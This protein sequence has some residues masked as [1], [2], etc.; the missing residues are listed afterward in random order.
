[1]SQKTL[2]RILILGEIISPLIGAIID[3]FF[4]QLLPKALQDYFTSSDSSEFQWGAFWI[5][6][7]L[8]IAFA[9]LASLYGLWR[10]RS[11][12]RWLYT[13]LFLVYFYPPF[14]EPTVSSAIANICSELSSGCSGGILVLI[15]VS[16]ISRE[17]SNQPRKSVK[18][19]FNTGIAPILI[20]LIC[21]FV[22]SLLSVAMTGDP[23]V[24]QPWKTFE[25]I[26]FSFIMY[27]WYYLDKAQH[28]YRAG[29]WLNMAVVGC[30]IIA[31]PVYL[32]R[33]RPLRQ[34]VMAFLMFL[35]VIVG[36][37]VSFMVGGGIGKVIID[38]D[39]CETVFNH[40]VNQS[41]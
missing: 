8:G 40:S 28:D 26:L 37:G 14:F 5:L 2:L 27:W 31:V 12:A 21:V 24:G 30:G 7:I 38:L 4:P 20:L 17:F 11:W 1:M 15:W 39:G 16:E 35:L 10:L 9:Y 22:S 33:S 36:V 32:F 18:E 41:I 23:I 25:I 34:A 19:Y 3:Q 6:S 29:K 13:S